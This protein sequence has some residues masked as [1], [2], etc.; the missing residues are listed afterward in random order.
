MKIQASAS[1]LRSGRDG[2]ALLD[3][4]EAAREEVVHLAHVPAHEAAGLP[5][6]AGLRDRLHPEA[7]EQRLHLAHGGLPHVA[8]GIGRA[9]L[10]DL[11]LELVRIPARPC[12]GNVK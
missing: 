2:A 3:A 10:L 5:V 6:L 9:E 7:R 8:S 11:R 4:S 1:T 12:P